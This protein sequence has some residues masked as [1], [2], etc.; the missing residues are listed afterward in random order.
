MSIPAASQWTPVSACAG[1]TQMPRQLLAMEGKQELVSTAAPP[2]PP[3]D[4]SDGISTA[5]PPLATV[6]TAGPALASTSTS[7]GRRLLYI[8]HQARS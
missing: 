8:Q 6:P 3:T 4:K 1:I 2:A 5:A 7:S